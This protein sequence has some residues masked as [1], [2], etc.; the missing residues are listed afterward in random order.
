MPIPG[1]KN[2]RYHMA[3]ISRFLLFF[4]KSVRAG[5][6]ARLQT[7][8]TAFLRRSPYAPVQIIGFSDY[9]LSSFL[10]E[11]FFLKRKKRGKNTV[12]LQRRKKPLK[13]ETIPF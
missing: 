1:R 3:G 10:C 6:N 9:L 13:N 11:R 2:V 5:P 12:I 4:F 7:G 8:F